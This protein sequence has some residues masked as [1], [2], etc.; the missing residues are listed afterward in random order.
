MHSNWVVS[1]EACRGRWAAVSPHLPPPVNHPLGVG[2]SS[3]GPANSTISWKLQV[4]FRPTFPFGKRM[5]PTLDMVA[6]GKG[7]TDGDFP[8]WV[9]TPFRSKSLLHHKLPFQWPFNWAF[10]LQA[11]WG[12][13]S[14]PPP[15]VSLLSRN[16]V[17]EKTKL[18]WLIPNFRGNLRKVIFEVI[19]HLCWVIPNLG[20]VIPSLSWAILNVFQQDPLVCKCANHL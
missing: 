4:Y 11:F 12:C 18:W 19:P 1:K 6:V 10:G 2:G 5:G 20:C 9:S 8:F 15:C 7:T 14:H 3:L 17:C 13:L 16:S